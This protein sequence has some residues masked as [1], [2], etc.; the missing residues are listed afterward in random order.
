MPSIYEETGVSSSIV[1]NI[2][3]ETRRSKIDRYVDWALKMA[4]GE[5]YKY[6]FAIALWFTTG[7]ICRPQSLID[8][9][10]PPRLV[11][12]II[13]AFSINMM[14]QLAWTSFGLFYNLPN[15]IQTFK[16]L[17]DKLLT[18]VQKAI[19][20]NIN[21]IIND[22]QATTWGERLKLAQTLVNQILERYTQGGLAFHYEIVKNWIGKET[23]KKL[24]EISDTVLSP[25]T[26][27]KISSTFKGVN[28]QKEIAKITDNCKEIM[29]RSVYDEGS[30]MD[31]MNSIVK[32][33]AQ[34]HQANIKLLIS[35]PNTRLELPSPDHEG[36]DIEVYT[37]PQE[38]H[39]DA[40]ISLLKDVTNYDEF[41]I[42]YKTLANPEEGINKLPAI[43]ENTLTDMIKDT[44]EVANLITPSRISSIVSTTQNEIKEFKFSVE[45]ESRKTVTKA[46]EIVSGSNLLRNTLNTVGVIGFYRIPQSKWWDT[47]DIDIGFFELLV[48]WLFLYTFLYIPFIKVP[49]WKKKKQ[50]TEVEIE[51]L[52]ERIRH[53]SRIRS[54]KVRS[55]KSKT[56][57][58]K[59]SKRKVKSR[60]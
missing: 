31:F 60:K 44:P 10:W 51:A 36:E 53:R 1:R 48:L 3:Y 56:N 33:G 17:S 18:N 23:A 35:P 22:L 49:F 11:A 45:A 24:L 7:F 41:K 40:F 59:R 32:V 12:F 4:V 20:T 9:G 46:V 21:L 38:G 13:I 5:R 30:A 15:P 28:Y 19:N 34:A 2:T 37:P 29:K 42:L 57:K 16:I 47:I 52:P 25:T 6:F 54:K 50:R 8:A 27:Q 39:I 26:I 55:L 14:I 58:I 43:I